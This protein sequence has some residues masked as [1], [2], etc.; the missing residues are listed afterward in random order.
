MEIVAIGNGSDTATVGFESTTRATP[1]ADTAVIPN[2]S[3]GVPLVATDTQLVHELIPATHPDSL[4]RNMASGFLL[5]F[6][7]RSAMNA[8]GEMGV[9]YRVPLILE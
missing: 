6:S 7:L 9:V 8:T 3:M 1:H 5:S 4:L 2:P